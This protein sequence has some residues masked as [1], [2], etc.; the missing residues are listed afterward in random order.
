MPIYPIEIAARFRVGGTPISAE[1]YSIGP[2]NVGFLITCNTGAQYVLQRI[3]DHF[4]K[5]IPRLMAN[6][7]TLL[8]FLQP[9]LAARGY[10]PMERSLTLVPPKAAVADYI[11]D[12]D[13]QYWRMFVRM[14]HTASKETIDTPEQAYAMGRVL[15]FIQSVYSDFHDP[16]LFPVF[17]I[18]HDTKALIADLDKTRGNKGSSPAFEA[19][20]S[21]LDSRREPMLAVYA[22][23]N[24][25]SIPRRIVVGDFVPHNLRFNIQTAPVTVGNLDMSGV[26]TMLYDFGDAARTACET[27]DHHFDL[28]RYQS[29]LRGFFEHA[30]SFI[31]KEE[32]ALFV[33]AILSA[34][35][36][37]AVRFCLDY[38]HGNPVY[39]TDGEDD[40]LTRCQ[41]QL[42][43]LGNV[44]SKYDDIKLLTDKIKKDCM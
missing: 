19:L 3:N 25:A 36:Q 12:E 43:L 31:T 2:T 22:A 34:T 9:R 16:S 20:L 8:A 35:Y 28:V 13:G 26:A 4:L 30:A 10:D 38:I 6:T 41:N 37:S 42:A 14:A 21:I 17:P 27:A 40:N 23:M 7:H 24:D 39:H 18:Y 1:P 11:V 44:E 32:L 29:F 33:D 15:G 5:D